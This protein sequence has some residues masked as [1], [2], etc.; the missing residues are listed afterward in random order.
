MTSQDLEF[1][2]VSRTA[3]T[4]VIVELQLHPVGEHLSY[5]AGQYVLLGDRDYMVPVRSYSV[6]NAP[7]RSGRI[8]LL[9]TA[10]PGGETSSWVH[11]RLRVGETVLLSGPYGSFVADPFSAGPV[12]CLAGGSGLAP[13]RA[14]AEDAV[15]R[16]VPVPF[17]VVFSARAPADVMDQELLGGWQEQHRDFWFLRTLTRATGDP[18][19]GRV[20]ELLPTLFHDLSGHEVFTAGA[21]GFVLGCARAARALGARPGHLHTEEFFAEPQ[22][23]TAPIETEVVS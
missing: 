2:V 14:L 5:A 15:H 4:P 12:L 17:T 13:I 11:E 22:P 21:P 18:P 6:A 23:W 9:V 3:P 7:C 16:G 19:T 1:T 20:P 10:V 8:S